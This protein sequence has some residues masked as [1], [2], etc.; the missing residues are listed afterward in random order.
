VAGLYDSIAD[1]ILESCINDVVKE[2]EQ[3]NSDIVDHVYN[4]E[5]SVLP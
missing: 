5:F 4:A 1:D 2:M 3:I